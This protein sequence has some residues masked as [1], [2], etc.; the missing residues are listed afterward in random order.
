MRGLVANMTDGLNPYLLYRIDG[1][2]GDC[3]LWQLQEGPRALALFLTPASADLY[4]QAAGLGADWKVLRP[5]RAALMELMKSCFQQGIDYAVLD[6][7]RDQA[8]RIFN[9]REILAAIESIP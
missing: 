9:I 7:T 3:A 4:K 1:G 5:A 6:P 2:D 8:K